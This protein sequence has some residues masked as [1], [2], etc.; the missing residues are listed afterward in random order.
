MTN[1]EGKDKSKSVKTKKRKRV[2][3]G[4]SRDYGV[5]G[6]RDK[7]IGSTMFILFDRDDGLMDGQFL[8]KYRITV[9]EL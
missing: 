6:I 1:P 4:Y 8:K 7:T 3:E 5:K 9:E 2:F